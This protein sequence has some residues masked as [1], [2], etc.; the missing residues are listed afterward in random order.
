VFQSVRK[1]LAICSY[2]KRLGR[3]LI[4]R[5]G[6]ARSYTPAQVKRTIQQGGFSVDYTCYALSM[7][8][9]RAAFDAYHVGIGETCDYDAMRHEA[10]HS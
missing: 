6:R 7:Y 2:R 10:G 1:W 3:K 9:D 4:E 8:C 5:Y